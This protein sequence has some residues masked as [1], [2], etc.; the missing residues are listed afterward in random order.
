MAWPQ[1]LS[2]DPLYEWAKRELRLPEPSQRAVGR[3]F[4]T[5][6]HAAKRWADNGIPIWQADRLACRLGLHPTEIWGHAF[7]DGV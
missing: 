3:L 5:D 1:R 4:G 2:Y 6:A 7:Y